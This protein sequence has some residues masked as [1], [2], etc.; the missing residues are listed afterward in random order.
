MGGSDLPVAA[1]LC[2]VC[3]QM[4]EKSSCRNASGAGSSPL[5]AL[6]Q[7]QAHKLRLV[8][9][10]KPLL[11]SE[12]T[13]SGDMTDGGWTHAFTSPE[14]LLELPRQRKLLLIISSVV[15]NILVAVVIEEAHCKVK[16]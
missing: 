9:G 4:T 11:I 8:P 15:V 16:W 14:A 7:D 10:A 12:E 2:Y 6:M 1:F 5:L 3:L 13:A